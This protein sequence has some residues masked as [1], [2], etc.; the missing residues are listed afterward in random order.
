MTCAWTCGRCDFP[1]LR[2][3]RRAEARMEAANAAAQEAL[4]EQT[5]PQVLAKC[6]E[7]M[8]SARQCVAEFWQAPISNLHSCA[9]P[10]RSIFSATLRTYRFVSACSRRHA[11]VVIAAVGDRGCQA[12]C[13][14][15]CW[16]RAVQAYFERQKVW[17]GRHIRSVFS[18]P[19]SQKRYKPGL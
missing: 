4:D 16:K 18:C 11:R 13:Y 2:T 8:E 9:Q 14:V 19:L 7:G 17:E 3:T 1:G 6:T 5:V 15:G 12:S 10:L